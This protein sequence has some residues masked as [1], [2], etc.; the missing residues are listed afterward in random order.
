MDYWEKEI[1]QRFPISRDPPEGG[2]CKLK[3]V[4]VFGPLAM[5]PISRD[6]PEGGTRR[7][8][9]GPS[10]TSIVSNF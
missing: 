6:P 4:P 2:T 10:S 1:T 9:S 3:I 5:F 7:K 8:N